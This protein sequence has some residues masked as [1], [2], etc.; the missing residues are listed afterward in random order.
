MTKF[1]IC[2][3]IMLG[4]IL[5][6]NDLLANPPLPSQYPLNK[7]K[8]S[9]LHKTPPGIP[10]GYQI[11][12]NGSGNS[13]YSQNSH[14]KQAFTVPK[15][16]LL[17]LVNDFYTIHFFELEDTYTVKKQVRLKDKTTVATVVTKLTNISSK[18]MCIQL[19]SFKKCVTIADNQPSEAAQLANKIEGLFLTKN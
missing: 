8:I 16:T 19:R 18:K 12:I 10:G 9:I 14:E 6:S 7:I 15:E 13:F 2:F 11:T 17:E 5:I 3:L 4:M 1:A